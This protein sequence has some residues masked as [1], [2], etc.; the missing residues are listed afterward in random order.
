VRDGITDIPDIEEISNSTKRQT[1]ENDVAIPL[2]TQCQELDL[3]VKFEISLKSYELVRDRKVPLLKGIRTA[4]DGSK[5]YDDAILIHQF[6]DRLSKPSDV[7]CVD[8]FDR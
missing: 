4:S 1:M 5:Y 6:K 8:F 3:D 7:Q 2:C